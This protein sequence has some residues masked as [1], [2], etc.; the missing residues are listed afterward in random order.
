MPALPGLPAHA[1]ANCFEVTA[2]IIILLTG[3]R[4]AAHLKC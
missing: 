3:A 4:F 2:F 1:S